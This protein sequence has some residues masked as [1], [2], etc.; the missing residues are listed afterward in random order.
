MPPPPRSSRRDWLAWGDQEVERV[1]RPMEKLGDFAQSELEAR[2]T[3]W[4]R[5]PIEQ[6]SLISPFFSVQTMP[7]YDSDPIPFYSLA[8]ACQNKSDCV[9][10]QQK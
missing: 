2:W 6:Q 8:S 7:C 4:C 5:R 9:Q 3:R 10:A 1:P